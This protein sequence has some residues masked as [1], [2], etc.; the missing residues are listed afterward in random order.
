MNGTEK[1][2]VELRDLTVTFTGGKSPIKAVN[3]VTLS[4]KRG[5]VVA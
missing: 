4:L 3:G 1:P 5:E 2:F